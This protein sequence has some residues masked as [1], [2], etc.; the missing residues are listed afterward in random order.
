MGR[1]VVPIELHEGGDAMS[2]TKK[3]VTKFYEE[4]IERCNK[5]KGRW[6]SYGFRIDDKFIDG[7]TVRLDELKQRLN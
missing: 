5:Y 7:L 1:N 4:L 3:S 6:S 2:Q